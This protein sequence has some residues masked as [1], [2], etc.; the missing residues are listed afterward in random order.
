MEASVLVRKA[1]QGDKEA[2]IQLVMRKKQEYYKLAYV[3]VGNKE[4]ALDAMEDMIVIIY[5]NISKLKKDDSFYT[6]S[7]TILVNCCKKIVNNS[8]KMISFETIEELAVPGDFEQKNDQIVLEKHLLK[9]SHK[10]QEVIKMRYFLDLDYQAIADILKIPLGT[11]KSRISY[12]IER[13]KESF[14]GENNE[15]H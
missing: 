15:D 1:K 12:G 3:Y 11:V 4:D 14:G 10:H 5:E 13:L 6:W 9:L 2:L 8:R 7:K